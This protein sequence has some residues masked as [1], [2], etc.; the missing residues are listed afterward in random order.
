[1]AFFLVDFILIIVESDYCLVRCNICISF[2]AH[3]FRDAYK[4]STEVVE[5]GSHT[6]NDEKT[7]IYRGKLICI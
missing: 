3:C 1:M 7:G 6:R 2:I 5:T 4:S